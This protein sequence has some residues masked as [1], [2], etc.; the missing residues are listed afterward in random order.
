MKKTAAVIIREIEAELADTQRRIGNSLSK[1]W[2]GCLQATTGWQVIHCSLSLVH[3][4]TKQKPVGPNR[5]LCSTPKAGLA[6]DFKRTD[7]G[8]IDRIGL[9]SVELSFA[10]SGAKPS[11]LWRLDLLRPR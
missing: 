3:P 1:D 2:D 7:P 4:E 6:H 8:L 11:V 5:T 10:A 9:M